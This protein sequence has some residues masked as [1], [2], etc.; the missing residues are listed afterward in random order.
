MHSS[1]RSNRSLILGWQS[2]SAAAAGGGP[3]ALP[4][5]LDFLEHPDALLAAAG[6][7]PG[8]GQP[9]LDRVLVEAAIGTIRSAVVGERLAGAAGLTSVPVAPVLYLDE[10][11]AVA[12]GDQDLVR[13][14]PRLQTKLRRIR[15]SLR[16]DRERRGEYNL[17]SSAQS[18]AMSAVFLKVSLPAVA[19]KATTACPYKCIGLGLPTLEW[20]GGAGQRGSDNRYP[21]GFEPATSGL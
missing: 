3:G 16:P 17:P 2:L 11:V 15:W 14:D 12:T 1:V 8:L 10:K 4:V 18:A 13:F 7:L 20:P 5:E 9:D 21:A 19:F 6:A